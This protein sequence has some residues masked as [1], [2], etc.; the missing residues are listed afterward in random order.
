MLNFLHILTIDLRMAKPRIP[1]KSP[2]NVNS[3]YIRNKIIS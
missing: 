3:Y 2:Q 1:K